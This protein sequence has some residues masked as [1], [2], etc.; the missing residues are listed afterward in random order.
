MRMLKY[1]L[2]LSYPCDKHTKEET[3]LHQHIIAILY[4]KKLEFRG[5]T[6]KIDFLNIYLLL[7]VFKKNFLETG[8]SLHPQV[9][10][11]SVGSN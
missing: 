4:Y 3:C 5:R 1:C 2:L 8:L 7:F 10:A 9:K 6:Y 11:Y